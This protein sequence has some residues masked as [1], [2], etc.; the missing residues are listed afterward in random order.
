MNE[1]HAID[2]FDKRFSVIASYASFWLVQ[3]AVN[4]TMPAHLLGKQLLWSAEEFIRRL[5]LLFAFALFPLAQAST[6]AE[7]RWD[8]RSFPKPHGISFQEVR[9]ILE[10]EEAGI[11]IATW[12]GGVTHIHGTVWKTYDELNGLPS[13][14]VRSLDTDGT[15]GVWVGTTRGLC[16]IQGGKLEVFSKDNVALFP[17]NGIHCVKRLRDQSIWVSFDESNVILSY[18]EN[19]EPHEPRWRIMAEDWKVKFIEQTRDELVW[20]SNY[21]TGGLRSYDGNRWRDVNLG[22]MTRP[23]Q[24]ILEDRQGTVFALANAALLKITKDYET[25][26]I[27]N[28]EYRVY[29]ADESPSGCMYVGTHGKLFFKARHEWKSLEIGGLYSVNKVLL[30]RD[31]SALWIGTR[32][33]VLRGTHSSWRR[34]VTNTDGDALVPNSLRVSRSAP[35]LCVD[36]ERRINLFQEGRW[37]VQSEPIAIDSPP[38]FLLREGPNRIWILT[39]TALYVVRLPNGQ[40]ERSIPIPDEMTRPSFVH[41]RPRK[42]LLL[43]SSSELRLVVE[44]GVYA[45][46]G[47]TWQRLGPPLAGD[48]GVSSAVETPDG[49]FYICYRND[50]NGTG[51]V[52]MWKGKDVI[53]MDEEFPRMRHLQFESVCS[54]QDGSIWFG[55]HNQGILVFDGTSFRQI[56]TRDGLASNLVSSIHEASDGSM[57][58][59]HRRKGVSNLR[60]GLCLTNGESHG[61]PDWEVSHFGED[62]HGN[63]W[64][65][66]EPG[67]RSFSSQRRGIF[68]YQ[69]ERHPPET[70]IDAYPT[71]PLAAHGIGVFSFSAVDAWNDTQR[72]SLFYSWRFVPLDSDRPALPWSIFRSDTSVATNQAP[73]A[74]GRYRFEVRAADVKRN[75]DPTP[76]SV[77]VSVAPPFW[78]RL[79]TLVPAFLLC[80]LAFAS[81]WAL[82]RKHLSLRA[83]NSKLKCE[84][85]ERMRAECEREGLRDQ[86]HQSQKLEALGTLA[87]GISHDFNNYLMAIVGFTEVL[88]IGKNESLNKQCLEGITKATEQAKNVTRALQTFSRRESAEKRPHD[89][90]EIVRESLHM[91][92]PMLPASIEIVQDLYA[93]D[94]LCACVNATQIQQVIVNLAVNGRDAMPSGGVLT[95]TTFGDDEFASFS[96]QDTGTGISKEDLARVF[97]P[98]FTTKPRGRG[99]GLGLSIVHGFVKDHLGH[100]QLESFGENQGTRITVQLPLCDERP[101]ADEEHQHDK[102]VRGMSETILIAEDHPEIRTLMCRYFE[103][104][105]YHVHSAADGDDVLALSREYQSAIQ[106]M[107]LD[108]DLPKRSG[109]DCLTTIQESHGRIPTIL[110]SGLS[111]APALAEQWDHIHFI[112]KPFSMATLSRLVRRLLD[113]SRETSCA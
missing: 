38:Q 30:T 14:W 47:S 66:M 63:M 64:V 91:L 24:D 65:S 29:S 51:Y 68:R 93:A 59:G 13:N 32:S 35:P 76:A 102:P 111:N 15:G 92:R 41:W 98:F 60:D 22:E 85:D 72:E 73:V 28:F 53:R 100:V 69:P 4:Y 96:V 94:T 57:W 54:C 104:E 39:S 103:N 112:E 113:S 6:S 108:M 23:V 62:Q 50:D 78:S 95:V 81:L 77:T 86:L 67:N 90:N 70:H 18:Q 61:L 109:I 71:K 46:K 40:V 2:S 55:T 12:G 43:T 97:D 80:V 8:I 107:I 42:Q 48:N 52:E 36:A 84:S 3:S 74:P 99:T 37:S 16:R 75:I 11:W 5:I 17:T 58:I 20:V 44:S 31:G 88:R 101:F 7:E 10:D 9:D 25:L 106:L 87:S 27:Q 33:G 79:S 89:L 83:S 45:L 105:G 19:V 56:T 34:H 1:R 21:N 110:I 49:S 82:F 26:P